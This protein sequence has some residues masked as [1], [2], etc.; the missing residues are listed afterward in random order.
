MLPAPR[1]LPGHL[2]LES[3]VPCSQAFDDPDW[4]FSVDWDGARALLIWGG[5]GGV[6]LQGETS[7]D[8]TARYPELQAAADTLGERA[9]VIEGVVAVLDA[10]GRPDLTA[11]GRRTALGADAATTL[12]AIFLA[13]DML[14]L[15]VIS[16]LDWTLDRRLEY[17]AGLVAGGD[18]IQLPDHVPARGRALAEAAGERG[19]TGLLARRGAAAYHPGVASPDRLRITLRPV[20]T[21][22]VVGVERR[23]SGP[24]YGPWAADIAARECTRLTGA[25][26]GGASGLEG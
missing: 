22:V 9:C 11:F 10:D 5:A 17:L 25:G 24:P 21:C 15:D 4:R 12:P 20:V 14:R 6:R 19:L 26:R 8:L 1:R 2:R 16:V 23:G 3:A 18:A 7:S 13:T